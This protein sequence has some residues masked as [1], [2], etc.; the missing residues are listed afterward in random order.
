MIRRISN[1][2]IPLCSS[3]HSSASFREWRMFAKTI[4]EGIASS[5]VASI[6]VLVT[7]QFL[8]YLK[9]GFVNVVLAIHLL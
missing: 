6:D 3:P 9:P 4:Q 2:L 8:M 7:V 1:R 5:I